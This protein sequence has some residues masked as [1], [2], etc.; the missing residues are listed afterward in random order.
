VR[1]VREL[2]G[3]QPQHPSRELGDRVVA[4]VR[5]GPVRGDPGGAGR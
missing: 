3:G 2:V 5:H 1:G 4:E